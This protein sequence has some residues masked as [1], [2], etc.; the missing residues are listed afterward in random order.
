MC[1]TT[2]SICGAG[3]HMVSVFLE[4][5]RVNALHTWTI[6]SI[7]FASARGD[8]DTVQASLAYSIP[9]TARRTL[10]VGNS[11]SCFPRLFL[12]M[13]KPGKDVRVLAEPLENKT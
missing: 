12:E 7:T 4:T 13:H 9:Q 6:T 5:V 3:M 8:R 1:I 2:G 10:S 11:G